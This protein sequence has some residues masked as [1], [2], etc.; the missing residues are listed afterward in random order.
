MYIYKSIYFVLEADPQV[1]II[2][3]QAILYT[4]QLKDR[5]VKI[6]MEIEG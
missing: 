4:S 2:V 3:E 1:S 5:E 6:E